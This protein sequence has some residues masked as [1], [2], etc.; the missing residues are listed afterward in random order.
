MTALEGTVVKGGR[1][2]AGVYVRLLGPSGEFVSEH[3]TRGSGTFRFNVAQG[4]WTLR[5]SSPAGANGTRAVELT[6]GQ[7]AKETIAID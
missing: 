6:E 1:P 7:V 3:R 2:I 4:T 5:W